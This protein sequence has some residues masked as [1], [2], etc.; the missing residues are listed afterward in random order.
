MLT[1]HDI[2]HVPIIKFTAAQQWGFITSHQSSTLPHALQHIRSLKT[3]NPYQSMS[4]ARPNFQGSSEPCPGWIMTFDADTKSWGIHGPRG[5]KSHPALMNCAS[6]SLSF[7]RGRIRKSK[8]LESRIFFGNK[9]MIKLEVMLPEIQ[10][11][12]ELKGQ[13]PRQHSSFLTCQQVRESMSR[14]SRTA[15]SLQSTKMDRTSQISQTC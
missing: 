12:S 11:R 5:V 6:S 3:T 9:K 1:I 10:P 2:L 4:Q 14:T 13:V 8:I 7:W 15:V